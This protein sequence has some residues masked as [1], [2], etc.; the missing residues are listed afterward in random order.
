M[1]D[2]ASRARAAA[3]AAA[4]QSPTRQS[5]RLTAARAAARSTPFV[6]AKTPGRGPVAGAAASKTPS[7]FAP[8]PAPV[9]PEPAS[10]EPEPVSKPR[11]RKGL[12]GGGAVRVLVSEQRVQVEAVE[13]EAVT[14]HR[15]EAT[16]ERRAMS[17]ARP[18]RV[19]ASVDPVAEKPPAGTRQ[20]PPAARAVPHLSLIHI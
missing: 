15:E 4:A 17:P 3:A 20:K 9:D 10:K 6:A 12:T 19:G 14:L 18:R 1:D 11:R 13:A 8:T 2:D 7:R 5:P 16:G